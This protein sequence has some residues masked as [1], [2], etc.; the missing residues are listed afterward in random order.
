MCVL[1]FRRKRRRREDENQ[2]SLDAMMKKKITL[3][4]PNNDK[5]K[6]AI[7]VQQ[8]HVRF[9][10]DKKLKKKKRNKN[11]SSP[12][13]AVLKR[14]QSNDDDEMYVRIPLKK[15]KVIVNDKKTRKKKEDKKSPSKES[16][17]QGN[18][19]EL[20]EISAQ[21]DATQ[22]W[23][24]F[25]NSL[26]IVC[27]K[28]RRRE[29]YKECY[30]ANMHVNQWRSRVHWNHV[31]LFWNLIGCFIRA[32]R[33]FPYLSLE[34]RDWLF[35]ILLVLTITWVD[36]KCYHLV[37]EATEIIFDVSQ[38]TIRYLKTN[39]INFIQ[40]IIN[41]SINIF[42]KVCSS[43]KKKENETLITFASE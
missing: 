22:V 23:S 29:K 15:T 3:D 10:D 26:Q 5:Y 21:M 6:N 38:R 40:P 19:L 41:K 39:T 33:D 7:Q 30:N 31:I 14:E 9:H 4:K 11:K 18:S 13:K 28:N 12:I 16:S 1:F 20:Q 36:G 8:L 34:S 37:N 35:Q 25:N 27:C 24:W 32:R 17:E 42:K 43:T 2:L